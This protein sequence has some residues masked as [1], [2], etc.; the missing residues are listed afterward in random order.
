MFIHNPANK[1]PIIPTEPA[2]TI[3]NILG[4]VSFYKKALNC[5]DERQDRPKQSI[6]NKIC[7]SIS[8]KAYEK[9]RNKY[10]SAEN[11]YFGISNTILDY[12]KN[13]IGVKT[14][15]YLSTKTDGAS[16]KFPLCLKP[17]P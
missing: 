11:I 15:K 14:L 5:I 7:T 3:K 1:I 10:T 16:D 4:K 13:I 2:R 8:A 12:Y 17:I 6:K 9:D